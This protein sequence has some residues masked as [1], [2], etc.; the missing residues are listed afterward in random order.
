[1]EHSQYIYISIYIYIWKVIKF[2]NSSHHQPVCWFPTSSIQTWSPAVP[3][4]PILHWFI[5]RLNERGYS[6]RSTWFNGF[7]KGKIYRKPWFLPSN[8]GVSCKFS[9][10]PILWMIC[11]RNLDKQ[12]AILK[13]W[14]SRNSWFA[15]QRLIFQS[16]LY[17]DHYHIIFK[18]W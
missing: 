16:F 11:Q 14:P 2:H 8:I 1:M 15:H 5:L 7:F 17:V 3:G 18:T 6:I 10:H 4:K 9:H 12:K 13:P